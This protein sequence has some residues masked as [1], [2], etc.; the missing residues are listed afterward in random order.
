VCLVDLWPVI[1][2]WRAGAAGSVGDL[3]TVRLL[4]VGVA[5]AVA[6]GVL[7]GGVMKRALDES[8][9]FTV[10]RLDPWGAYA[11]AVGVYNLAL[12]AAAGLGF[13][14]LL[15][16]EN[17]ALAR[18]EWKLFL[19]WFAG[20]VLA[21]ALALATARFVLGRRHRHPTPA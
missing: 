14:I 8:A 2:V 9:S 15:G 4:W 19:L 1:L 21:A 11:L 7:A 10:G 18:N 5:Y 13:W 16:D 12:T 3:S 17:A 20:R 6:V